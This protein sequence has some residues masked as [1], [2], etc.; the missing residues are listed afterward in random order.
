M[1]S[2]SKVP[3]RNFGVEETGV[4]KEVS[5]CLALRVWVLPQMHQLDPSD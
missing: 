1:K 4:D 3:I 2:I 5:V